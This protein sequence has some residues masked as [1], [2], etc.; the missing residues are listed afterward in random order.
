MNPLWC[1]RLTERLASHWRNLKGIQ[2]SPHAVVLGVATRIFFGF[3]PLLGLKTLLA[4]GVTRLL[5]GNLLAAVI[6]VTLH[7]VLLPIAPLIAPLMLR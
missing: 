7:D 2:D 3:T 6:A 5:R 4:V 1:R